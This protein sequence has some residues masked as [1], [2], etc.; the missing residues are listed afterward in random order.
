MVKKVGKLVAHEWFPIRQYTVK[1]VVAHEW[2]P[3]R[4]YTVKKV[5]KL[6]AHIVK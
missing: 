5:G 2:F 1:K 4:E 3:M 6:V